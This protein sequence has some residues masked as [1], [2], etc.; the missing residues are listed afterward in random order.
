[1]THVQ[2]EHDLRFGPFR[3]FRAERVTALLAVGGRA[4]DVLVAL[5][6][7]A[8]EVV[9]HRELIARVG[10]DVTGEDG[11]LSSGWRPALVKSSARTS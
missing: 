1:M 3:L 6:E 9:G 11:S 2:R 4:L 5:I 10:P 8:G 7:R